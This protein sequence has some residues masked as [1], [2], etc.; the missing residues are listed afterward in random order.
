MGTHRF[1]LPPD[2]CRESLVVLSDADSHHAHRVLRLGEGASIELLDGKGGVYSASITSVE[3]RQVQAEITGRKTT[4]RPLPRLTLI[5]GVVKHKG[6]ELLIQ[7]ATEIGVSQIVPWLSLRSNVRFTGSEAEEK[8][9]KW[10]STIVEAAKQ[11]G[12][13]WFPEIQHAMKMEE[14]RKALQSGSPP[15]MECMGALVSSS[16]HPEEVLNQYIQKHDRPPAHVA[17]WV[18]PEGDFAPEESEALLAH[19]VH[20]IRLGPWVLRAETAAIAGSAVLLS[21]LQWH[22]SCNHLPEEPRTG[23]RR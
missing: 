23:D 21:H 12:A 3:N 10:F 2:L 22:G 19:G 15:E 14:A 9:R 17:F 5:Q 13:T 11:C 7:K 20:P 16:K 6:M 1:Y 8:R 18:G 4:S